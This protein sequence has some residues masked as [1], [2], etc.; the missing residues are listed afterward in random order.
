[1]IIVNP[2]KVEAMTNWKRPEN[3]TQVRS[4]LGWAGYYR[5]FIEGFSKLTSLMI[6]LTKKKEPYIWKEDCEKSFQ[7]LKGRLCTAPVLAL[8]EMGKPY[9][10]YTD[11]SKEGLSGVLMQERIAYISRK[12]RPHKENYATHDLELA[13]I[14]F[15]LKKW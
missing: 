11:T 15:A 6:Q 9:E 13:A 8:P 4:F 5:Q 10:V 7:E 3:P 14:V 12:L 1:V 2:A